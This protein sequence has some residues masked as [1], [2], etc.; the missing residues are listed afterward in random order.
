VRILAVRQE[1]LL[2]ISGADA[3]AEGYAGQTRFLTAFC[4]INKGLAEDCRLNCLGC[5]LDN[6]LVWVVMF[7]VVEAGEG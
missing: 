1:R 2:E 3:L 6:P 5:E 7:R 4:R